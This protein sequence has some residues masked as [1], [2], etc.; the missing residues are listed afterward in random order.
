MIQPYVP[1]DVQRAGQVRG[2][3]EP[4]ARQQGGPALRGVAGAQGRELVPQ[5]THLGHAVQAEQLSQLAGRV[6]LQLLDGLDAAQCHEAQQSH[7]L[8]RGVVAAERLE[9]LVEVPEQTVL[10][11]RGKGAEHAAERDVATRFELGRSAAGQQSQGGA[12]A[13]QDPRTGHAESVGRCGILEAA[14]RFV[15]RS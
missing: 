3:L 8:Q 13:I 6:I 9:A 4:V 15:R 11:Q 7:D 14:R 1:I 12:H 5:T 2:G 10:R